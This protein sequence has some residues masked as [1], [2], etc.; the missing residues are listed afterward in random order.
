[1]TTLRRIIGLALLLLAGCE[2]GQAPVH[3]QFQAY[4]TN[5][6]VQIRGAPRDR[7]EAA[8]AEIAKELRQRE[9]EWHAWEPSDL[10][11]INA[12]FAAGRPALAPDSI[13]LLLRR[14]QALAKDSDGLFDPA[15]GGLVEMWGFHTLES[16]IRSPE[17]TPP[18]IEQ[19]LQAHP[20]VLD[21]E[22]HGNVLSSRNPAVQLDFDAL[23]EGASE[24]IAVGILRRHGIAHALISMG[25]DYTSLGDGSGAAWTVELKDPFGGVLGSIDLADTEALFTSGNY[26][27]FRDAPNGG[28]WG[29]VLDPRTGYPARGA[30][31]VAVLHADPILADAASTTLM[32][33]GPAE[34]ARLV[35]KFN[36]GCAMMLTEEN[37]LLITRGMQARMHFQRDP[38]PLGAP[39]DIGSDCS[40]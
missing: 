8:V 2:R 18:Q 14:S 27:K 23:S 15:V 12:A 26:N 3:E 19:W 40:R 10:T 30:A 9:K 39:L 29:H 24:Q 11:R 33:G 28:R 20:S 36:L 16:P 7:A 38:I 1:M 32:A 17:P 21:V 35:R 25:N 31:A 5:T 6:D 4:G 13:L 22:V 34:F 37:E